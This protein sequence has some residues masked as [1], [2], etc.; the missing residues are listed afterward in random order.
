MTVVMVAPTARFANG[1]GLGLSSFVT[2]VA[3][4]KKA[5]AFGPNALNREARALGLREAMALQIAV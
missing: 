5:K 2:G 4:A 1:I 3:S